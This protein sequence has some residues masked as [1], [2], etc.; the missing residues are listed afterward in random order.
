[1]TGISSQFAS[2]S[3]ETEISALQLAGLGELHFACLFAFPNFPVAVSIGDD[4]AVFALLQQFAVGAHAEFCGAC[5]GESQL[6]TGRR[7]E[8]ETATL[9]I[10][11]ISVFVQSDVLFPDFTVGVAGGGAQRDLAGV[12]ALVGVPVPE[13]G[14]AGAVGNFAISEM[15]QLADLL[16]DLQVET[17][18]KEE[19]VGV[20]SAL[21]TKTGRVF[22]S[23]DAVRKESGVD[24]DFIEAVE[25]EDEGFA[26]Q[27]VF[28]CENGGDIGSLGDRVEDGEVGN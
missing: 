12:D 22:E 16:A 8:A 14:T 5:I 11:E 7:G 27:P 10:F 24:V 25:E 18:R 17:R 26:L 20:E 2:I 4:A 19:V 21:E 28:D 3:V 23:E 6:A 13:A 9:E 15:P 1:V